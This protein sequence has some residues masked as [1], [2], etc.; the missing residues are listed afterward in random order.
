MRCLLNPYLGW[1][2]FVQ[3]LVAC[4]TTGWQPST[5]LFV[6]WPNQGWRCHTLLH[7]F[8]EDGRVLRPV[9]VRLRRFK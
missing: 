1:Q 7:Q 8:L 6:K 4:R 3:V 5:C 2:G 9:S